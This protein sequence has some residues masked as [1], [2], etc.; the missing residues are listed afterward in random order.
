MI[1]AP[2]TSAT[3]TATYAGDQNNLG[4]FGSRSISVNVNEMIQITVANSGPAANVAL[5]GCSALPAAIP[6]DGMLHSF[7]ATSGCSPITV[8]LPPAGANSRYL[9]TS[10][11]NSLTIGGC[12]SSSCQTFSAT[13]Y[14]QVQNSYQV[15]PNNPS[16]WSTP[17]TI[18]VNGTALGSNGQTVCT[19]SVSTGS[20]QF[21]CQ[22]WTDYNTPALMGILRVSQTQRWATAQNSFA[23]T[24]GANQHSSNYYSQALESFQYSVA[25]GGA[26]PTAPTLSFV[27]FGS[28]SASPLFESPS[29]VWLDSGSTWSVPA[30]LAGSTASER[31]QTASTYGAATTAQAVSLLYY[32]QYLVSFTSSV[33]GSGNAYTLPS[34]SFLSLGSIAKGT[35]SWVDAGSA[36][37]YTNPLQGS[38]AVERWSTPAPS[39]TISGA[40]TVLASYYHQYGFTL[41][42]D[43]LGGGVYN[44]P[45]LNFT[46]F[47]N[48]ALA[49]VNA[50]QGTFWLDSGTRWNVSGLLPSS[51]SSERWITQQASSGT[52]SAPV[53]TQFLYYHQYLGTLNYSIKGSGG[54]PPVPTLNYTAFDARVLSPLPSSPSG[55][56]MDSA[57]A[58]Y[59]PLVLPGGNQERWLSNVTGSLVASAPFQVDAQ[60]THQ[61]FLEVGVSTSAGGRVANTNQ[62]RD[63]GSQVVLNATAAKLWS[64]AYWQG[65]TL[66]S[67]N[68]TSL[69][70]TLVVTGPANETAIFFPGLTITTDGMGSVAYSY[71]KING[72]VPP[73]SQAV[74]YPPPGRNVTVTAIPN[75]V[76]T[77]FQGW[78][79]ALVD[80]NLQASVAISSP[81]LLHASF[82]TDYNDI[83]TFAV[84]AIGVFL[85]ACYVLIIKRGF[86]PKI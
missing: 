23:D 46:S 13:I 82:A 22:G 9:T 63:Q 54:S 67:Y 10:G 4:T 34:V 86:A 77:M 65:A 55:F 35:Q 50:T 31:W 71:G 14:Y 11:S 74:V 25:G 27:A 37:N 18:V 33:I 76:E 7:Q 68:G 26:A 48:T 24:T 73:A 8:T 84:A 57:S 21:S 39:G 43:V 61:F 62:W 69:P 41:S 1:Y 64:F 66:F 19:I 16:S 5:S 51:S 29:S 85:A 28:G 6:A 78:T 75:T 3:I 70:A 79:G 47:A 81:S 12:M 15:V 83:R 80:S 60:Y 42:F 59:V 20:G 72:S 40:G 32:H 44:D 2:T 52:V 56:W 17:G 30:A 53:Q 45:R 38:T 36:Y 58:W 49:Q